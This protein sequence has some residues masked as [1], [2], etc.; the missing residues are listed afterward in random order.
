MDVL[1]DT[2]LLLRIADRPDPQRPVAGTALRTMRSRGDRLL[3]VPQV[4]AEF[5]A[6]ATRPVKV[7]GLAFSPT[8]ADR[9]LIFLSGTQPCCLFLL[10][11]TRVGGS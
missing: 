2:N 5:W 9:W 10:P 1:V 7:R 8:L 3:L 4:A 6:V 11:H